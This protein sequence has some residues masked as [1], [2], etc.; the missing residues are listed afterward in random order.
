MINMNKTAGLPIEPEDFLSY[1][2]PEGIRTSWQTHHEWWWRMGTPLQTRRSIMSFAQICF[3]QCCQGTH[4]KGRLGLLR[5]SQASLWTILILIL[6]IIPKISRNGCVNLLGSAWICL[7]LLGSAWICL[8]LL[9]S[10][11]ICLDLLGSAWICLDLL[12]SAWICLDLL[13][14]AWICLDLLGSAWISELGMVVMSMTQSYLN[15]S[16]TKSP[17]RQHIHP[18]RMASIL[19]VVTSEKWDM[20][21][22]PK[23][24]K[25][26]WWRNNTLKLHFKKRH[27]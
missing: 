16:P 19:Q 25:L 5:C 21:T 10:A 9:G 23:A 11:W 2:Q 27:I 12:G 26:F 20:A 4:D 22:Q 8:D 13:G 1:K 7:D 6:G 18:L 15:L 14:S 24:G 3:W 17:H